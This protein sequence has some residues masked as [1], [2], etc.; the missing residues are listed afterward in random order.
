MKLKLGLMSKHLGPEY[1][2]FHLPP[3]LSGA[4]TVFPLVD[5]VLWVDP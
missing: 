2:C 4:P 1:K 3:G 5:F